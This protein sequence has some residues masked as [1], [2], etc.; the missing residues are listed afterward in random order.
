[1]KTTAIFQELKRYV[2]PVMAELPASAPGSNVYERMGRGHKI[3]LEMAHW[4]QAYTVVLTPDCMLSD[5]TVARLQDLARDGIELVLAPALRFGEEPF[6]RHLGTMGILGPARAAASNRWSSPGGNWCQPRSRP[7]VRNT[8][9]RVGDAVFRSHRACSWWRVPGEEGIVLHSL[10]RAALLLDYG[11]LV[12]HDTSTPDS[13]TL[14][15][16][17]FAADHKHSCRLRF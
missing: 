13:W 11:V 8:E 1:M 7:A 3:A 12:E 10:S 17:K 5:G 15:A 9:L 14:P 6:L 4:A 2:V 16:Q